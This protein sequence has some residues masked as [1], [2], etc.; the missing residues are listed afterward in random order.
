MA[1]DHGVV[2]Y[3]V[4]AYPQEVTP[5][6]V[7][8][9][10]R[11]GAGINVLARQTGAR[12]VIVDMGIAAP[13]ESHPQLISRKVAPG[14]NNLATGPAMTREQ[15]IQSIQ[16][17]IEIVESELAKGLDIVGTGDMGIGNTTPSSAICAAI[18]GQPVAKITGRGTGINDQQHA[19]KIKV[20]EQGLAVNQPD[21]KDALDV[22][23]KVG[24][25]E[26]GGLA[27]VILGAAHYRIPVVIDGFISGAAALIAC[28]LSSRARDYII[29][30]HM[31]VEP[32]H[33]A[34]LKHLR[35][36]PLLDLNL[37]LGE[38]TGATLGIFMAECAVRVLAEMATF[39]EAGVSEASPHLD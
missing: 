26:I 35:L 7:Y 20:I 14:T 36:K 28:G 24:G 13:L 10:L 29:A 4:S 31:S 11:G 12:V 5:Q 3:G 8:N 2:A 30:S 33:K 37:R 21:S 25:F 9:F 19:H 1:G 15:A 38:G 6:M 39:A 32:G 23:T 34:M 17:G 22:L 18:T 16:T 27:G